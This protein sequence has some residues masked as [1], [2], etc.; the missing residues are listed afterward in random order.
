MDCRSGCVERREYGPKARV[1]IYGDRFRRRKERVFGAKWERRVVGER[2]GAVERVL[3]PQSARV[4]SR[5]Q[6]YGEKK[7]RAKFP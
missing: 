5:S 7:K 3:E 2:K 1:K 4:S 6:Q